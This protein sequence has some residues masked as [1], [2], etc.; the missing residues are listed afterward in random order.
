MN[1]NSTELYLRVSKK[2]NWS[3]ITTKKYIPQ[4]Y[5]RNVLMNSHTEKLVKECGCIF[6]NRK[7]VDWN[8]TRVKVIIVYI[9]FIEF[10]C[11]YRFLSLKSKEINNSFIITDFFFC[12]NYQNKKNYTT[13][14]VVSLYPPV[15]SF[16]SFCFDSLKSK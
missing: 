5:W 1:I 16:F 11:D 7:K 15:H 14:R 12:W 6:R 13:L 9:V 8:Q 4:Q 3:S 2:G 10:L